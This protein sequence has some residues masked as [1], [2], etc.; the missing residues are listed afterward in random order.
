MYEAKIA[1][2]GL[3]HLDRLPEKVR[4][5]ALE[6]IFGSIVENP[7]RAGKPLGDEL[8]GLRSARRG[9]YRIVYEIREDEAVVVI[10]RIQHRRYVYRPS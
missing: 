3:R 4:Q 2:A 10:H 5:A 7:Y 9:G 8:E 6:T 1:A